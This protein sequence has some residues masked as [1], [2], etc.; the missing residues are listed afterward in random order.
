V[1]IVGGRTSRSYNGRHLPYLL[2]RL[3]K[4]SCVERPGGSLPAFA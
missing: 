2:G 3:V 4:L 1:G